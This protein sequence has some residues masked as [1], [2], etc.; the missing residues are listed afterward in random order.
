MLIQATPTAAPRRLTIVHRLGPE[1]PTTPAFAEAVRLGLRA[2]PKTL[3]WQFFYDEAGSRL[4][5]QICEQPEYSLTRTEDAILREHAHDMIG[6]WD[7]APALVELGSGSAVKT[8]RL[9]EAALTHYGTLHYVPIDVSPTFIE[10]SAHGLV[11]DFPELR[12]TGYVA[13]YQGELAR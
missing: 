5:D 6:G 8:R 11:R 10:E 2:R 3:P 13:D 7:R 4:F 9:I 12:V 1:N